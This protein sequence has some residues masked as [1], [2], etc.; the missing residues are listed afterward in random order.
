VSDSRA[1]AVA[2]NCN[3]AATSIPLP[4]RLRVK[5]ADPVS[6]V[7]DSSVPLSS[8]F[9][10]TKKPAAPKP[11]VPKLP[12]QMQPPRAQQGPQPPTNPALQAQPA[13]YQEPVQHPKH[14]SP[15]RQT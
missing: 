3:A 13:A 8:T 14:G 12:Q 10:A 2:E 6:H 11:Q 15:V 9:K 5:A 7:T 1:R 4:T